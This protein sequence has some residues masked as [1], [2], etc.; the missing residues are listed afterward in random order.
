M[1]KFV[2]AAFYQFVNLPEFEEWQRPL[3][4]HCQ[5]HHTKGTILLAPEGLNGTIAGPRAGIDAVLAYLRADK[6][7]QTMIHKESFADFMPFKRLKVRLKKEI[8]SLRV[9]GI[10]PN[11]QVGQY[12]TPTAWNDLIR[13]PDVLLI[14]TRNDF[15]VEVGT[16][17]GAVNPQTAAFS[18]FPQF[19]Q[20]QLNPAQHK[21]IAMFCTGGIRCEKATAYMLQQGFEAVYHLQGGILKYLEDI[22]AAESMWQGECFV[23]DER[24]TV[25]HAL[26][27]GSYHL[28]YGCQLPLSPADKDHPDYEEGVSCHRCS[29]TTSPDRKERLRERQRQF[30]LTQNRQ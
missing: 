20:N 3:H 11:N 1:S 15:E 18:D 8:V 6:R 5:Q 12:I 9:P 19:V 13:D 7:L 10:N 26:E 16:F 22:P 27:P 2:I 21:K 25:N 30:L 29:H 17:Q 24:V 23:F 14:D 4:Q 28:C